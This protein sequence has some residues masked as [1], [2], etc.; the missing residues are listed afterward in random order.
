MGD[1]LETLAVQR[2]HAICPQTWIEKGRV[3]KMRAE[4]FSQR[5]AHSL[6]LTRI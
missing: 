6:K 3:G 2:P 5:L 1:S 4:S